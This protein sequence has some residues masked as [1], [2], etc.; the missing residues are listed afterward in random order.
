MCQVGSVVVPKDLANH[1]SG[2]FSEG[3]FLMRLTFK[4]LNLTTADY[5]IIWVSLIQSVEG[6]KG[7][8]TDLS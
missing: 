4:S 2:S 7:A 6:L 5:F 1:Y 8:K 3:V